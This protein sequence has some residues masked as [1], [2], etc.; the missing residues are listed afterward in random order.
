MFAD[1]INPKRRINCMSDIHISTDKC[2]WR[3]YSMVW[4]PAIAPNRLNAMQEMVNDM[5]LTWNMQSTWVNVRISEI[6]TARIC[7]LYTQ[8]AWPLQPVLACGRRQD[9]RTTHAALFRHRSTE[10]LEYVRMPYR[11]VIVFPLYR[12]VNPMIV[13]WFRTLAGN[14]RQAE[15]TFGR[16]S[17]GRCHA[18]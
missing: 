9:W 8:F 7:C 11:Y 17:F 5:E 15:R 1:T 13:I 12:S 6:S 14:I 3:L 4:S 18:N 2:G 10:W 16:S